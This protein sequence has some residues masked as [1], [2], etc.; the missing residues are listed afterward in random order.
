MKIIDNNMAAGNV[1]ETITETQTVPMPPTDVSQT[2]MAKKPSRWEVKSKLSFGEWAESSR[3]NHKDASEAQLRAL[4]Q[5]YVNSLPQK[6][7]I[8]STRPSVQIATVWE[9]L[10]RFQAASNRPVILRRGRDLYIPTA[11][12]R[13]A[14]KAVPANINGLID[15]YFEWGTETVSTVN[16]RGKERTEERDIKALDQSTKHDMLKR[17]PSGA[18]EYGGTTRIP[19]VLR[20]SEEGEDVRMVATPGYDRESA[21][22]YDPSEDLENLFAPESRFADAAAAYEFIRNDWFK[23]MNIVG[24]ESEANWLAF[25]VTP[26]IRRM[27]DLVP[28]FGINA[29]NP[30][31]GKTQWTGMLS[32]VI[33]RS[34][35]I[36]P[37]LAGDESELKREIYGKL[38]DGNQVVIYDNIR[39]RLESVVLEGMITSPMFSA[40][41]VGGSDTPD[42]PNKTVWVFTGNNLTF[43]NDL[44]LRFCV[45]NIDLSEA[46]RRGGGYHHP[47]MR[48]WTLRNR[49]KLVRALLTII[50]EGLEKY[51]RDADVQAKAPRGF[52]KFD[53]WVHVVWPICYNLGLTE[54]LSVNP[55]TVNRGIEDQ[56]LAAFYEEAVKAFE[57]RSVTASDVR[58]L[59]EALH[60]GSTL[61]RHLPFYTT[62]SNGDV[63]PAAK[64]V[65]AVGQFFEGAH[66]TTM[67]NGYRCLREWNSSKKTY[68]MNF[69]AP[70]AKK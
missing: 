64:T 44:S 52:S 22:F 55:N 67:M 13:S 46:Q 24:A 19:V 53:Q 70:E 18:W 30:N 28:A 15:Q 48:E 26:L 41:G 37:W 14:D 5:G 49:T 31:A 39:G 25:L 62:E 60:E 57:G 20:G 63:S 4:Y 10:E 16:A 61:Y 34:Q 35:A 69:M 2:P 3:R 11:D 21:L 17:V 33:Q 45:I 23:D 50:M 65:K 32:E 54:L 27:V 36:T 58:K 9:T 29:H 7:E 51:W 56:A 38:Q 12:G 42:L 59:M 40:R 6:G 68:L 8:D 1:E 43:N 66:G 47:E